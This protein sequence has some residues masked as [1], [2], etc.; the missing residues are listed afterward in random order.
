MMDGTHRRTRAVVGGASM[1]GLL[2][3]RVLAERF[4]AVVVL[5][6]DV[7][8]DT[9]VPRRGVP[10][11]FHVHALLASGLRILT[12]QFPGIAAE[13]AEA[14]ALPA[15][16]GWYLNGGYLIPAPEGL[17]AIT[18][19]R[20]LIEGTVCRRLMQLGNVR[21]AAGTIALG[22]GACGPA[23]RAD[24]AV[25][26]RRRA[27]GGP[28]LGDRGGHRSAVPRR[29][30]APRR[31]DGRGER[32]HEPAGPGGAARSPRRDPAV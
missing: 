11:G 14:G 1:A 9:A 26:P 24:P 16:G 28:A 19:S 12:E 8:P 13:L 22:R 20:P 2:A 15:W 30:R 29:H 10:Q 31:A 21:I 23:P 4:D 3:A 18:A 7:L 32:L 25:L 6:K 17:R 27:V 5:D